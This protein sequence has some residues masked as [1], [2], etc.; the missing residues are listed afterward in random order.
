MFFIIN[1][2]IHIKFSY[3]GFMS[4]KVLLSVQVD[5]AFRLALRR[6]A[7]ERGSTVQALVT[8]ALSP[9]VKSPPSNGDLLEQPDQKILHAKPG[10]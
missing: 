4:T 7:L 8:S 3:N 5:P 10:A 1:S 2:S 6:L 9:L